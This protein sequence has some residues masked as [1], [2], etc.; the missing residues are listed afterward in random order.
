MNNVPG[1]KKKTPVSVYIATAILVS[2]CIAVLVNAPLEITAAL[3]FL[4]PFFLVW[5]II[6][7]LRSKTGD[8]KELAE[9]EEW[10]YADKQK[11]DPGTF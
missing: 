2:Y 1:M 5:M 4:F 8:T 7:V 6:A 10:G 9:G 3:F 11:E